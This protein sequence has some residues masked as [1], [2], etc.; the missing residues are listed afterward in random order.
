M[1]LGRTRGRIQT[2]SSPEL[3]SW[4]AYQLYLNIMSTP[5][6]KQCHVSVFTSLMYRVEVKYTSITNLDF[7]YMHE[8]SNKVDIKSAVWIS[9]WKF[10]KIPLIY[11]LK[12][13]TYNC[14]IVLRK[15]WRD[16][17]VDFQKKLYVNCY[18]QFRVP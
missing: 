5:S 2:P 14:I 18:I 15:P 9:F 4:K 7:I 3:F 13:S 6:Q 17:N 16:I 1:L 11:Q 10:Q 8:W 12:W